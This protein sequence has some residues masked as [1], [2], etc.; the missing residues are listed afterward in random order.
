MSRH[1]NLNFKVYEEREE[2]DFELES[3][4]LMNLKARQLADDTFP[5]Q[6]FI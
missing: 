2:R 5:M 4:N 1:L 6:C 3:S